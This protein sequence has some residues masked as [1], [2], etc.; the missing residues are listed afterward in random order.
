MD[1]PL[2]KA[3]KESIKANN[4][5]PGPITASFATDCSRLHHKAPCIVWGPGNIHQAHQTSEYISVEQLDR[6]FHILRDFL[7]G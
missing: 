7:S 2:I 3:L 1:N 5:D 6:A 4:S